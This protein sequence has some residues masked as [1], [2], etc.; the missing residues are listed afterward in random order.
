MLFMKGFSFGIFDQEVESG[1][2]LGGV[3]DGELECGLCAIR[4]V[5]VGSVD[6]VL[7]F[8][9]PLRG[10]GVSG[11]WTVLSVLFHVVQYRCDVFLGEDT[12]N[13]CFE[14]IWG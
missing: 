12:P 3:C 9:E 5:E 7:G 2:V 14:C 10:Q 1:F 4:E 11:F 8:A 6:G 13:K